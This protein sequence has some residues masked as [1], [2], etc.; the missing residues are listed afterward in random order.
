MNTTEQA[1]IEELK[2]SLSGTIQRS[3]VD[4]YLQKPNAEGILTQAIGILERVSTK[5]E[6]S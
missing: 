5:N 1:L 6:T 3:L 2:A 4:A